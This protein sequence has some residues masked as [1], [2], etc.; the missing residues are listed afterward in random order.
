MKAEKKKPYSMELRAAAAEATRERILTAA[1]EAFLEGWY[2]DVTIAAIAE[3][4]GVSGQTVINHF[5]SKEELATTAY[6]HVSKEITLRRSE[7]EP[8]DVLGALDVLVD[9]YEITGDAVIRMLALEEKVPMLGATARPRARWSPR[10]GGGD[11]PCPRAR[12]RTGGGHRRLHL[13]AP[14]PRPGAQPRRDPGGDVANRAS[15]TRTEDSMTT[16]KRYLFA[17]IDGGGTVPADTS[18]IRAMVDR[19]HDVRVLADR[20]LAPDIAEHRRRT[21]GL[22]PRASAAEPRPAER[23]HEG[24]GREDALRGVRASPR[25]SD[26]RAGGAVRGGRAQRA[27]APPCG[28]CRGQLLRLRRPDRCRGRGRAV[29]VPRVEPALVP[30]ARGHRRSARA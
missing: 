21:R 16:P 19:G 22:G 12:A 15:S 5:G 23:D 20:V 2:D 6:E 3:R 11:V 9:D 28:R 24:L 30:R 17:I 26:G 10:L 29:R 8:G 13:E 14:A 18:V 25:R 7:P 1:A 27:P 4:A